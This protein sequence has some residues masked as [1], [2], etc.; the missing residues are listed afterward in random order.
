MQR[1]ID[2]VALF[3]SL[4]GLTALL[5]GGV[6]IGNA[7]RG[8]IAG[9]TATIAT[10]KCLGASTRPGLRRLSDRGDGAGAARHSRG[11]LAHRRLAP[12]RGAPLL[13]GVLPVSA[14]LGIYPEPLALAALYGLLTTLLF[15][16]WPLAGDRPD[17]G[18]RLVP[19]HGRPGPSPHSAVGAGGDRVAGRSAW[20]GWSSPARRTAR[21][22]LWFIAGAIGAFALFRAAGAAIVLAARAGS[23][24]RGAP[25]L[26]LALANLHRPGAPNAADRAVARH[27]PDRAGRG[28]AGRGQSRPRD[29]DRLPA[30][31]PAFFFI[32][33]QPDQLAGFEEIVRE[34]PGARLDEVPM[35][36]GRIT[37]LNGVPV[38]KRRWRPKRDGHCA[39][40]AA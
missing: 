12:D 39:A 7:V 32:D 17:P 27:R 6:G 31:A 3:L 29:R 13:A 22:A 26:R 30:A 25:V 35:M 16:L 38:E 23:A 14:R 18:R 2:R 9:K 1:L 28:G 24:G 40:T 4:V 37:R 8:H 15:S 34:N 33:I 20:P 19:R 10:L 11:A 21:V 36:R 5:V